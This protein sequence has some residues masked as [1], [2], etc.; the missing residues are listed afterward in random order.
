M[1]PKHAS[2][3][4]ASGWLFLA[5]VLTL[6]AARLAAQAHLIRTLTGTVQNGEFGA[7]IASAGDVDRDRRPDVLIGAPGVAKVFLHSGKEGKLLRT[8]SGPSRFGT[9]LSSIGDINRDGHGD[10]IVGATAQTHVLSSKDGSLIR[11]HAVM[12]T[13]VAAVGDV[14]KDLVPDYIV[15]SHK[16]LTYGTVY[17]FSGRDGR[18]IRTYQGT[19]ESGVNY[20]FTLAAMG[21]VNADGVPDIAIGAPGRSARIVSGKANTVIWAVV[22]SGSSFGTWVANAGDL[23]RDGAADLAVSDPRNA[24][25]VRLFSGRSG[26]PLFTATS[27]S[28]Q[29]G[30]SL[31]T[32]G[33]VDRDGY[34]D[35][36]SGNLYDDRFGPNAGSI[37]VLSGRDGKRLLLLGGVSSEYLGSSLASVG[38]LDGD[39]VADLAAGAPLRPPGTVRF[40]SGG[41]SGTRAAYASM[42]NASGSSNKPP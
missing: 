37:E 32:A 40:F 20:G 35:I 10:W 14:D 22:V 33:D 17:L 42:F 12:G 6:P 19:K 15:G 39:G 36:A 41:A 7:T 4:V 8:L 16:A 13:C 1:K 25:Y 24:Q 28:L 27:P 9:S 18:L 31:A 29:L 2:D 30:G 23:D 3:H 26:K 21:D 34:P 11:K 5:T 38:D